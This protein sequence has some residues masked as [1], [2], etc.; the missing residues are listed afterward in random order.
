M[1]CKTD[2]KE[3]FHVITLNEGQ[4]SG[5]MT[6]ELSGMLQTYLE[7]QPKNIVLSVPGLKEIDLPFAEKL[8]VLQQKFYENN[9]SFVICDLQKP[10]EDF[11]DKNDLLEIMNVTPTISEAGD[12]VQ[13][14][15][16]ER[17]MFDDEES[18]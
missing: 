5:A 9:A 7:K 15:E 16:M 13:M 1:D 11:L 6:D 14:E 3:K 17:E 18:S 8:A 2:T 12:I 10:V 4:M